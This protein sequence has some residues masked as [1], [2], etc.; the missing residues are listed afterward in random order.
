MP[1]IHIMM[2]KGRDKELKEK[3]AKEMQKSLVNVL[4]C[5]Y[6]HISVSIE[7]AEPTDFN[8]Q[9]NKKI[10]KKDIFINSEYVKDYLNDD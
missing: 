2:Y 8:K 10:S 4:N 1:H 6:E 3:I 7:D 5:P 9:I